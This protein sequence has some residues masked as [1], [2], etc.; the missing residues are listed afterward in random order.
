MKLNKNHPLYKEDLQYILSTEGINQLHGK[1]FLITGATGMV[2]VMLID[3]LMTLKDTQV[4][5]VGRIKKKQGDDS[6]SIL[7]TRSSSL[8]STMYVILLMTI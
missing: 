8:L 7:I 3:V 2:G 5:A 6:E 1:S 4:Y